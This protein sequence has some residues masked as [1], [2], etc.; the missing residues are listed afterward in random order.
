MHAR[1]DSARRQPA[2]GAVGELLTNQNGRAMTRMR[3]LLLCLLLPPAAIVGAA[4]CQPI[5]TYVWPSLNFLSIHG[6]IVSSFVPIPFLLLLPVWVG[7]WLEWYVKL[8]WL[9]WVTVAGPLIWLG[10]LLRALLSSPGHLV[11]NQ[12]TVYILFAAVLPIAAT[13]CGWALSSRASRL[14]SRLNRPA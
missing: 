8:R 3:S 10:L 1:G 5:A 11:L 6:I 7:Y 9:L 14:R 12:F 13:L 2:A 4:A